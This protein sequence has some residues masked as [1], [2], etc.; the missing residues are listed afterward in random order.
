MRFDYSSFDGGEKV[1]REVSDRSNVRLQ[2]PSRRVSKR[3]INMTDLSPAELAEQKLSKSLVG[4]L[5][6]NGRFK[7]NG[8]IKK[9]SFDYSKR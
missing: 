1:Y 9:V 2:T 3:R 7:A 6:D 8:L 4:C 5:N